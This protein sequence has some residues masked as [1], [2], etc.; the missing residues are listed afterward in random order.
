MI[1]EIDERTPPRLTGRI[2]DYRAVRVRITAVV[3]G[4]RHVDEDC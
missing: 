1:Q 4:C 2:Q 3:Q